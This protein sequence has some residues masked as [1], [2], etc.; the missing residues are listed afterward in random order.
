MELKLESYWK[1][2]DDS[3]EMMKLLRAKFGIHVFKEENNLEDVEF[4]NPYRKRKSYEH[5]STNR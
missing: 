3:D 2:E 5:D 4:T 1:S